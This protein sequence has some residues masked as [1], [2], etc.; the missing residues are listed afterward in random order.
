[1][2]DPPAAGDLGLAR[3]SSTPIAHGWRTRA[4]RAEMARWRMVAFQS[5]SSDGSSISPKT[6]STMPSRISSLSVT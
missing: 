1:M 3:D 4:S 6:R 5:A 2:K